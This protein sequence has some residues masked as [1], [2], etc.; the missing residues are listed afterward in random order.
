MIESKVSELGRK[1]MTVIFRNLFDADCNCLYLKISNYFLNRDVAQVA[2]HEEISSIEL[3]KNHIKM[4]L[5]KLY[6]NFT[7]NSVML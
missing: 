3:P 5:N 7:A 6:L 1:L 4:N 2:I